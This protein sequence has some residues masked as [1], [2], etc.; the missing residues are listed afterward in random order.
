VNIAA[1]SLALLPFRMYLLEVLL[2]FSMILHDLTFGV[3][4]TLVV[5]IHVLAFCYVWTI[6]PV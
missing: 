1:G 6:R 2:A 5:V 3:L 4:L